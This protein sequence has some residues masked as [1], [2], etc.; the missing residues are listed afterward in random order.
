MAY[1]P[2]EFTVCHGAL[3]DELSARGSYATLFEAGMQ[4]VDSLYREHRTAAFHRP[5]GS[6]EV[7]IGSGSVTKLG[8]G[9]VQ[10]QTVYQ[11]DVRSFDHHGRQAYRCGFD[12]ADLD[13]GEA[14]SLFAEVLD[15]LGLEARAVEQT[16]ERIG[17]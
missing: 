10:S 12:T 1:L 17:S 13:P 8:N 6:E 7:A 11:L 2:A 5:G 16:G 9:A 4:T 15:R 14:K 3:H